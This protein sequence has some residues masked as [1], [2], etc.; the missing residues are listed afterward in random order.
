[1][2]NDAITEINIPYDE[3]LTQCLFAALDLARSQI[4]SQVRSYW[5]D[6]ASLRWQVSLDVEMT[7]Q[8]AENETV[9]VD[10]GYF[11]SNMNTLLNM[12]QFSSSYDA[13]IGQLWQ[14]QI[15]YQRS[16]SGWSVS[17]I[18]SINVFL[19]DFVPFSGSSFIKTPK[20]IYNKRSIINVENKGRDLLC[21]KYA[22]AGIYHDQI[23]Q[24]KKKLCRPSSYK[25]FLHLFNWGG[26]DFTK[27]IN[28]TSDL[29]TFEK[30]NPDIS[31]NVLL[32]MS[33]RRGAAGRQGQ[34]LFPLRLAK[35]SRK[36][37]INLLFIYSQEFQYGHWCFIKDLHQLCSRSPSNSGKTCLRCITNFSGINANKRYIAHLSDCEKN[38]PL[39]IQ[40][41]DEENIYFKN[42][43]NSLRVPFVIFSDFESILSERKI[44]NFMKKTMEQEEKKVS[45]NLHSLIDDDDDDD[46]D[47][48]D[49]SPPPEKKMKMFDKNILHHHHPCGF[50]MLCQAPPSVQEHFPQKVYCGED[51]G[52]EFIKSLLEI[53]EKVET[54]RIKKDEMKDVSNMLPMTTEELESHASAKQCFICKKE[55]SYTKT[56]NEFVNSLDKNNWDET[57]KLGPK[58]RDH[59]E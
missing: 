16:G 3:S 52:N 53:K 42:Y 33:D 58:V 11:T 48:D 27:G 19:Y 2:Y 50:S 5:G 49:V 44:V 39:A 29:V 13:I 55:F 15:A 46:D 37:N 36:I 25:P 32:T 9:L 54:L 34:T 14:R 26:L 30:N 35:E 57:S 20:T 17:R 18:H 45:L 1:M 41:P 28:T 38:A 23:K 31:L 6:H 10:R 56:V 47:V 40:F 59:G 7:K 8:S 43:K 22:V 4:R 24:K 51:V 21:F 12:T